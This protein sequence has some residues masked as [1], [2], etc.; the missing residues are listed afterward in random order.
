MQELSKHVV[1]L[2]NHLREMALGLWDVRHEQRKAEEDLS[3]GVLDT[4]P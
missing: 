4:S 1:L 3:W 2:D